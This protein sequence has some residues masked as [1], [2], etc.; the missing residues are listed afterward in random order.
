MEK[1]LK[2]Y[3]FNVLC[4]IN[5]IVQHTVYRKNMDVEKQLEK[6][7]AKNKNNFLKIL[8]WTDK[9]QTLDYP[10]LKKPTPNFNNLKI[11]ENQNLLK[12][13]KI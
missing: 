11:K 6:G 2:A 10:S 13:S 4:V 8:Y 7:S 1:I 9:T 3:Q 12:K 5:A